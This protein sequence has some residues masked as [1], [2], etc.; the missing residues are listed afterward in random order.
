MM[1]KKF[2]RITSTGMV[3]VKVLNES[4]ECKGLKLYDSIFSNSNKVVG[5]LCKKAHEWA[6]ERIAV[7]E[8]GETNE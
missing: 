4:G 3:V 1:Y 8:R 2:V 6:D 5:K 7:C